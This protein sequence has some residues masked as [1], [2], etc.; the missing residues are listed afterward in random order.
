MKI[1]TEFNF[2]LPK[3]IKDEDGVEKKIRGVMRLAK[4][5]DII[6]VYRDS[7]INENP[8]YFY[9]ILLTKV[10]T[11]LTPSASK[12]VTNKSIEFFLLIIL[13]F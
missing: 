1:R 12:I 8:S 3:G 9:I 5:S 2:V 7:R 10:V 6:D 4:V 11:S 13:L